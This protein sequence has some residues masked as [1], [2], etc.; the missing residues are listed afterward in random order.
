MS[1]NCKDYIMSTMTCNGKYPKLIP[2]L[3]N[4]IHSVTHAYMSVL[5]FTTVFDAIT[6]NL[7]QFEDILYQHISIP[8]IF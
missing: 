3:R 1:G 7:P 5:T 2:D 4:I 6:R 8:N